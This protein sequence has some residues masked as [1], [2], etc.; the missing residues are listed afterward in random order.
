MAE[1]AQAGDKEASAVSEEEARRF[2][3]ARTALRSY[4]VVKDELHWRVQNLY[5]RSDAF[6]KAVEGLRGMGDS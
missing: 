4:L 3:L 5:K 1:A 6:T 2:W